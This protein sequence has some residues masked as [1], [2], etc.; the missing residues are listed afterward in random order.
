LVVV[1]VYTVAFSYILKVPTPAFV[2]YLVSGLLAWGYFAA[3]VSASTGA[4]IDSGSLVKSVCFP[5]AILPIATV[6]FNLAQFVLTC[7]AAIPVALLIYGLAP[8]WSMLAWPVLVVLQTLMCIGLA[9]LL[10]TFTAFFRDIRHLLDIALQVLF[11]MTPII[12]ESKMVPPALR[13]LSFLSPM[14]PF[15]LGYHQSLYYRHWPD[16]TVWI[17]ACAYAS[18]ACVIG[19][20]VFRRHEEQFTELL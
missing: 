20:V 9:L 10:S 17:A 12:Y 14:T 2:L 19:F 11:W 18:L 3:A 16:A 13:A 15:A 7:A 6:L 5:R 8:T 1:G 4:V